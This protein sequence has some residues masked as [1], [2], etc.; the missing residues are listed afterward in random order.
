MDQVYLAP[1]GQFLTGLDLQAVRLSTGYSLEGEWRAGRPASWRAAAG[2][3]APS[4]SPE[5]PALA[6]RL[7]KSLRSERYPSGTQA[8]AEGSN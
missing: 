1:E 2:S 6:H 5:Q 3:L 4:R 7:P 8:S